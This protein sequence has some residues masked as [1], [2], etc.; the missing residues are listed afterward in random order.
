MARK[1]T[2]FKRGTKARAARDKV[3][4]QLK[5]RGRSASRAFALATFIAK[6]ASLAGRKRLIR[7]GLRRKKG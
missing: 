2:S 1:K 5:R 4:E 6:R 7:H 3:A